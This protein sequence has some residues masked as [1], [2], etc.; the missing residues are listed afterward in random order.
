[1]AKTDKQYHAGNPAPKFTLKDSQGN[2]ISLAQFKG[3]QPVVLIFYPGDDTPGCTA[4]LCAIRD[5][6]SKFNKINAAVFGINQAG[7]ESHNKF[8]EKYGFKFPILIDEGREVS[9][10]YGAIKNMFG[11]ESI[12][13]SVVVIDKEGVIAWVKRGMPTDQEILTELEKLSK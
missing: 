10:K 12:K 8:I 7:A 9:K 5:D 2:K 11:H 6:Y 1:M 4:Q 13:R 3:Q